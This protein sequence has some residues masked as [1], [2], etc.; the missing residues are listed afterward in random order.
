M[1]I[2]YL[3]YTPASF[4]YSNEFQIYRNRLLHVDD[5]RD[6]ANLGIYVEK[7]NY[8]KRELV[9]YEGKNGYINFIVEV[10][11]NPESGYD[12]KY[13]GVPAYTSIEDLVINANLFTAFGYELHFDEKGQRV[14]QDLLNDLLNQVG[15]SIDYYIDFDAVSH[16]KTEL[17]DFLFDWFN[18]KFPA[19]ELTFSASKL[20]RPTG[21][22]ILLDPGKDAMAA[23][24]AYQ[25]YDR[26]IDISSTRDI[27]GL[28]DW[29]NDNIFNN[30]AYSEIIQNHPFI[31]VGYGEILGELSFM[32]LYFYHAIN[33]EF[34]VSDHEDYQ[35]YSIVYDEYVTININRL[36]SE[37]PDIGEAE[38]HTSSSSIT[39][40]NRWHSWS[41]AHA[42]GAIDLIGWTGEDKPLTITGVVPTTNRRDT[43]YPGWIEVN[44]NIPF[45]PWTP[46]QEPSHTGVIDPSPTY[47]RPQIKTVPSIGGT[48][49]SV[50]DVPDP[51]GTD[52]EPDTVIPVPQVANLYELSN[53]NLL[54]LSEWLWQAD[55]V[56]L[57]RVLQIWKNDPFQA[58]I[59]LQ[60]MYF[61]PDNDG[62]ANIKLGLIDTG[63]SVP[64]V[65]KRI[66]WK[67]LGSVKVNRY[68]NDVRDYQ[69]NIS[70]Y[71]PFIGIK[72]LNTTDVMD[73]TI[74]VKY[75]VDVLTGDCL[76]LL[77][78]NRDGLSDE[79]CLYM[80]DGNCASSVPL[81]GADR[82]RLYNG[83]ANAAGNLIKSIGAAVPGGP[84]GIAT[85]AA[86]SLLSSTVNMGLNHNIDIQKSGNMS[87]NIGT[88]GYKKAY[89]IIERPQPYDAIERGRF[90]GKPCNVTVQV[91]SVKGY[92][93][94]NGVHVETINNATSEE[95]NEIEQILANG[96]IL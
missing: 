86:G 19:P 1:A 95:R 61:N 16:F 45:D 5:L 56:N 47:P 14:Q 91:G 32:V 17:V 34:I 42:I 85:A 87:G 41:H 84:A 79:K 12:V 67:T 22:Q 81:T 94:I 57:D 82:S 76:A 36:G 55:G 4:Y 8:L 80:F 38:V 59:S 25:I 48:I 78:I 44:N 60:A 2:N 53:N 68:F 18:V 28:K 27:N 10:T 21:T 63:I 35:R 7:G 13:V 51:T 96:V 31:R 9:Q 15:D 37:N 40:E 33:N 74:K 24:V 52:P 70:I 58:I 39:M 89:L 49:P 50:D 6:L 71:L 26:D 92:S 66:Q 23:S 30:A 46:E 77:F 93:E 62:S 69:T 64:T 65:S 73:S 20:I 90:M 88:M 11:A 3:E 83:I 54:S 75:Y 72:Q 43:S 29:L